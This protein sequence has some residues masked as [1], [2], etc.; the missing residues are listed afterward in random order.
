[1]YFTDLISKNQLFTG[2]HGCR[3]RMRWWPHF[4]MVINLNGKQAL[5]TF[6]WA[7]AC[8]CCVSSL[9][10]SVSWRACSRWE[11][12]ASTFTV[13]S[14]SCSHFRKFSRSLREAC[15]ALSSASKEFCLSA[16]LQG[17][18]WASLHYLQCDTPHHDTLKKKSADSLKG[19]QFL[20]APN[21]IGGFYSCVSWIIH[22][23]GIMWIVRRGGGREA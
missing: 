11:A 10:K 8:I 5:V 23:G 13:V 1:M 22:N 21:R 3:N 12:S 16:M 9:A 20:Q 4:W 6:F 18:R 17:T 7:L 14:A 19:P 2:E 15:T